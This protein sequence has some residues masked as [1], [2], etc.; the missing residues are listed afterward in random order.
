LQEL[1]GK[2]ISLNG[3]IQPLNEGLELSSFLL[4]EYPVGCWYCEMP[5][6]TGIVL[7]ELAPGKTGTFTRGL[8]KVVGRLSLNTGDPESFL[9]RIQQAKVSGVD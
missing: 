3:F 7:V 2:Q 4:I 8:V 9:Y 1:D 5:E 6:I